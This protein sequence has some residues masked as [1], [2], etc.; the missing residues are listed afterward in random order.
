M[1]RSAEKGSHG[2]PFAELQKCSRSYGYGKGGAGTHFFGALPDPDL[3][4]WRIPF[5]G[6]LYI[7]LILFLLFPSGVSKL[8]RVIIDI[9]EQ[10]FVLVPVVAFVSSVSYRGQC[11]LGMQLGEGFEMEY[12]CGAACAWEDMTRI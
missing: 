4:P 10:G 8:F 2:S 11:Q 5:P 9:A 12:E 6:V 3:L 1:F 7:V